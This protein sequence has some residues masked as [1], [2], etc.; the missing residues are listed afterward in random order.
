MSIEGAVNYCY[1]CVTSVL[2]KAPGLHFCL[3]IMVCAPVGISCCVLGKISL[4][5][6]KQ[7][8]YADRTNIKDSKFANDW[9]THCT[10]T[11]KEGIDLHMVIRGD[12]TKPV[13]LFLHGF[14]DCW[15]SWKNQMQFFEERGYRCV[16]LSIRGYAE[17]SKPK[18]PQNY[19]IKKL[20]GD[21]LQ[22]IKFLGTEKVILV[23]HDWG[24]AI[25]SFFAVCH[26]TMVTKLVLLNTAI[27]PLFMKLQNTRLSQFLSSWY[28][29]FFQIPYFPEVYMGMGDYLGLDILFKKSIRDKKMSHEELQLRKYY[30]DIP[31]ALT[32]MINYYRGLMHSSDGHKIK[33]HIKVPTKIIWGEGDKHL[34][35]ENLIGVEKYIDDVI[36]VTFRNQGHFVQIEAP[37]EVNEEILKFIL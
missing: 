21:V 1:Q 8:P 9:G 36:I 19:V 24:G 12:P 14:P 26:P 20:V 25:A 30:C 22:T 37:N 33:F 6:R 27:G 2:E 29:Y 13:I 10:F 34:W 15:L 17:S 7:L 5:F 18:G 23:G 16:A 28:I 11:T 4:L 32:S 31:G 3:R 35:K